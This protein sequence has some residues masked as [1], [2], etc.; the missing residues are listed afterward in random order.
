LTGP[1]APDQVATGGCLCG[2]VR[3]SVLGEMRPVVACHCSQCRKTSGHF[4][5]ATAVQREDLAIEDDGAVTWFRSSS[6]AQRGFCK[7][8]GSNLFWQGDEAGH[9][10]IMAGTLDGPTGLRTAAHIFLDDK[11]DYYDIVGDF[12]RHGDGNHDVWPHTRRTET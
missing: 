3:Y 7:V 1:A 9:T 10:S 5:S 2:A 4:V 8:C 12:A 11:G 6:K